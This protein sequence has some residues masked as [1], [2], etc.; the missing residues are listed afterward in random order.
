MDVVKEYNFGSYFF[1]VIPL[2]Y[3]EH[4]SNFIFSHQMILL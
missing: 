2:I 1:G 3:M 4:E